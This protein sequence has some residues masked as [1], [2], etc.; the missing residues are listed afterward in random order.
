MESFS[1]SSSPGAARAIGFASAIEPH[2]L[3]D[4]G[5]AGAERG[6]HGAKILGLRGFPS[7]IETVSHWLGVA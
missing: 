7:K 6:M 1:K 5:F 3:V 2:N 4:S